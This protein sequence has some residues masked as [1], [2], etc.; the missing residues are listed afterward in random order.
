[1]A[2]TIGMSHGNS[3]IW[4]IFIEALQQA[5]YVFLMSMY[6]LAPRGNSLNCDTSP[7]F[8]K[9]AQR[10]WK[11]ASASPSYTGLNWNVYLYICIA[12]RK[13]NTRV[14]DTRTARRTGHQVS[15]S[16]SLF[17]SSWWC[18]ACARFV[19]QNRQNVANTKQQWYEEM[20]ACLVRVIVKR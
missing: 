2:V 4:F 8:M 13:V 6:F 7:R 16:F 20:P 12:Q 19:H 11:H 10:Q 18:A 5:T 3:N 15:L 17:E 14:D 1:M 9:K